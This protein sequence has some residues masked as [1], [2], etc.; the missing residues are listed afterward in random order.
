MEMD[1][2]EW[3]DELEDFKMGFEGDL[4][5]N[6]FIIAGHN[7]LGDDFDDVNCDTT[8]TLNI[9]NKAFLPNINV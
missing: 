9:L 5:T 4:A 1:K 6:V 2:D 8:P 3:E 7:N